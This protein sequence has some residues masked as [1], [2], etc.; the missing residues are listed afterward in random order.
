VVTPGHVTTAEPVAST[1]P[2]VTSNG[3]PLVMQPEMETMKALVWS[4]VSV[5]VG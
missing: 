2:A 5:T 3:S 4:P 1:S